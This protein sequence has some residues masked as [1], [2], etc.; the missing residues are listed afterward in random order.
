M[1]LY[2]T[3]AIIGSHDIL[4]ALHV[5]YCIQL[6]PF[7]LAMLCAPP[8]PGWILN[9]PTALKWVLQ[10]KDGPN[11]YMAATCLW[12]QAAASMLT[13]AGIIVTQKQLPFKEHFG[14][15]LCE[16]AA[17][18]EEFS[19]CLTSQPTSRSG[20]ERIRSTL[21][22]D[23]PCNQDILLTVASYALQALDGA[24][25]QSLLDAV[26]SSPALVDAAAVCLSSFILQHHIE[27]GGAI[28]ANADTAATSSSNSRRMRAGGNA[29]Q[30][31]QES[32]KRCVN[33]GTGVSGS[34][35]CNCKGRSSDSSKGATSSSRNASSTISSSH[36]GGSHTHRLWGLAYLESLTH[37]DWGLGKL[38]KYFATRFS[39]DYSIH[40]G[41]MKAVQ[42]LTLLR[43]NGTSCQ[44]GREGWN[45]SELVQG[46]W[47][48]LREEKE[49]QQEE[50]ERNL[51]GRGKGLQVVDTCVQLLTM[52]AFE[53]AEYITELHLED[54]TG[55]Q[56]NYAWLPCLNEVPGWDMQISYSHCHCRMPGCAYKGTCDPSNHSYRL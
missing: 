44:A 32:S 22:S 7:H 23:I 1:A 30:D 36:S 37:S 50:Q 43:W 25:Q 47:Q 26:T 54:I 17:V 10:R 2:G 24:E 16:M 35:S 8:Y 19:A 38:V 45:G 29:H 31:S 40:S 39:E 15:W 3:I 6:W 41:V 53:L 21:L 9:V 46:L 12:E 48:T 18:W 20:P 33:G 13:C 51:D 28:T 52:A 11:F 4:Q 42:M 5:V 55:G 14:C 49:E 56:L 27:M 34:S